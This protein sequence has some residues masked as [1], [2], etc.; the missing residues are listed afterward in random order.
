MATPIPTNR[1]FD[2]A[3]ATRC[4]S[5]STAPYAEKAWGLP[6]NAIA[7]DQANR[8][9]NQRGLIDLLR[10][11]AGLGEGKHYFYPDGGFGQIPAAYAQALAAHERATVHCDARVEAVV[12]GEHMVQTVQYQHTGETLSAEAAHLVWSAPLPPLLQIMRPAAPDTLLQAAAK[13]RY[14]AV[15]LCY[16]ALRTPQVGAADTYYFP[17]REFPF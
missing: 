6:G 10:L 17:Q 15:V 4:T 13:L 16:V 3:W 2:P 8:R 7:A 9:V 14:R 1:P 11:A 12:C 5:C